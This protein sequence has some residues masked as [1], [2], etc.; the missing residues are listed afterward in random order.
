MKVNNNNKSNWDSDC[1]YQRELERIWATPDNEH[2]PD[3]EELP[4]CDKEVK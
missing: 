3:E 1:Y 2:E 4:A